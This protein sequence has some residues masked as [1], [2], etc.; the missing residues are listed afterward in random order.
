M[1]QLIILIL[2]F[3]FIESSF[4]NSNIKAGTDIEY[5]IDGGRSFKKKRYR[6]RKYVKVNKNSKFISKSNTPFVFKKLNK[7]TKGEA[8]LM[9]VLTGPLGGHRLYLGT[10][11]YV[12]IF[13]AVTLGGGFGLLPVIDIVVIIVSKDL[14]KYENNQQIIMWGDI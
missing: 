6:H 3:L 12:P 10:N 2:F 11:P 13:Y 8:I 5:V 9:A 4:A 14:S 1:K 7:R